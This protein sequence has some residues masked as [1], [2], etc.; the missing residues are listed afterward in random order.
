MSFFRSHTLDGTHELTA[1]FLSYQNT[2]NSHGQ[3]E[4]M[5]DSHL[6]MQHFS[7]GR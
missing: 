7:R 2:P 4:S 5:L 3:F 1:Y 6:A